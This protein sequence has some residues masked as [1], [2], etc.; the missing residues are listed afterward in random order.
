MDQ[1]SLLFML[2][3]FF[4]TT[5]EELS[6]LK[7][8]ELN[9]TIK[10]LLL[11]M[12]LKTEKSTSSSRIHGEKLGVNKVTLES[13]LHKNS[14]NLGS[15]VSIMKDSKELLLKNEETTISSKNQMR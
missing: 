2:I 13:A 9:P 5:R 15:A 4:K 8:V 3:D 10:Y 11:A 6:N 7:P 14:A 12:V 1:L